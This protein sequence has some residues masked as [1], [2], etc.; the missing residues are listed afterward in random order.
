M[1]TL[2]IYFKCNSFNKGQA[3][4]SGWIWWT[5]KLL[6]GFESLHNTKKKQEFLR[7]QCSALTNRNIGDFH[8]FWPFFSIISV[9]YC[10]EPIYRRFLQKFLPSDFSLQNIVSTPPDTHDISVKVVWN[11]SQSC[12]TRAFDEAENIFSRVVHVAWEV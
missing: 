12:I 7:V 5:P 4:P 9:I 10:L 6:F 2:N 1:I 8:P 3:C 11:S